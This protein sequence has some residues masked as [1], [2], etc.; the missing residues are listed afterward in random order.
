MS[1]FGTCGNTSICNT[2]ANLF[3][4]SAW[5]LHVLHAESLHGISIAN[6]TKTCC[7]QRQ[8]ARIVAYVTLFT[9]P[10]SLRIFTQFA[11]SPLRCIKAH[12]DTSQ[13]VQC[14]QHR[15]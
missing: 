9:P 13:F 10:L 4:C 2:N 3:H 8:C 12:N 14:L 11:L 7:Q 5:A 15:F 1:T 6:E